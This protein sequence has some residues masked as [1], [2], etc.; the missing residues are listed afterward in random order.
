MRAIDLVRPIEELAP[1][2]VQEKWD[3]CGFSVGDPYAEVSKALIALDCTEE[4]V[5]EAIECGADIIIAHHPLIFGGVKKISPQNW[6]GRTI[7]KAIQHN[8]TIYAAHTNMDKAAGGVSSAMADKLGLQ[9]R[10]FLTPDS[11]GVVGSLQ[12]PVGAEVFAGMVKE[13]FGVEAVRCSKLLEEKITRVAVCGGSGKSFIGDAMSK[14]AQ[15]YITGD[16]TYHEFYTEK[17]FMIMD[18]G[19]YPSEYGIVDVFANILSKNFPTFAVSIS[20]RNNNP[21]YYH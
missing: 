20:K 3:N 13:A 1:L 15:V 11:F 14:G 12:E 5:D 2:E 8:I 19:H 7:I 18:I 9:E 4:V 21:I 10:E 17:G 6:L 16:V